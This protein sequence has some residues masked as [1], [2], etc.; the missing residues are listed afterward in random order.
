MPNDCN[1][2]RKQ[3]HVSHIPSWRTHADKLEWQGRQVS[4]AA[5]AGRQ[6]QNPAS[7]TTCANIA[8]LET[9]SKPR[10]PGVFASQRSK[11]INLFGD[12]FTCLIDSFWS[13]SKK[14]LFQW[15]CTLLI[16][17]SWCLGVVLKPRNCNKPI[18]PH[19]PNKKLL[20]FQANR[21][22]Q[23]MGRIVAHASIPHRLIELLG[24][25]V[26]VW[27]FENRPP[28]LTPFRRRLPGLTIQTKRN[29]IY[30]RVNHLAQKKK[31]LHLQPQVLKSTA[32]SPLW[33][34]GDTAGF[35]GKDALH[36]SENI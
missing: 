9:R 22:A 12:Q 20:R 31:M 17:S 27:S 13:C 32:L 2:P 3:R 15:K 18:Q 28:C 24:E 8:S 29:F 34:Q 30:T 26:L 6:A 25:R 11:I 16:K 7:Q 4:T 1:M 19:P 33:H 36:I 10:V 14:C 35:R 5:Q 21:Q 23:A